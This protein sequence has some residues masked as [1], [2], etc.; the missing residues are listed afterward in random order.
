MVTGGGSGIG[1]ASSV[2]LAQAG[3]DVVVSDVDAEAAARTAEAVAQCGVRALAVQ[4]DVADEQR[5]KE[6]VG[7]LTAELGTVTVLHSNAGLMSAVPRDLDIAELE[8]EVW[9]AVMAVNVKGSFLACK[10][11]VPGMRE[12]GGGSIVL[13][14]SIAAYAAN[15]HRSAYAT[16]KGALNSFAKSIA[17]MC[18]PQGIR[19]NTVAPGVVVTEGS[20]V[21]IS[22]ERFA[23][24]SAGIPLRRVADPVDVANVVA[25]LASDQAAYISGQAIVVDGGFTSQMPVGNPSARASS[26]AASSDS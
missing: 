11:L 25:F 15:V 8:A 5:W 1:A 17:V 16:S 4:L 3:A 2:R 22:D 10:H 7:E 13:T 14:S 26:D 12:A 24:M 19:C 21:A 18:G 20:R 23:E 6:V 9:D